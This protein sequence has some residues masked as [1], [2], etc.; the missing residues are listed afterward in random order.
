MGLIQRAEAAIQ[1]H[2]TLPQKIKR[3][4]VSKL[5]LDVNRNSSTTDVYLWI[6]TN[7][8]PQSYVSILQIRRKEEKEQAW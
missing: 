2:T 3:N 1:K 6:Q 5:P 8:I 4:S 7:H